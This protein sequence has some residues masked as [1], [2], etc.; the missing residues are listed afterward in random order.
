MLNLPINLTQLKYDLSQNNWLVFVVFFSI[1]NFHL[2]FTVL[3]YLSHAKKLSD[4]LFLNCFLDYVFSLLFPSVFSNVNHDSQRMEV[5]LFSVSFCPPKSIIN[6]FFTASVAR[7]RRHLILVF[8][9]GFKP[10]YK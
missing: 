5:L 6:S 4:F 7:Q 8:L 2:S 10:I 3:Y 9:L 1:Y